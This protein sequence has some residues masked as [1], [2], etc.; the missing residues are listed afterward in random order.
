LE[1][2]RIAFLPL[3]SCYGCQVNTLDLGEEVLR[4]AEFF[5]ISKFSLLGLENSE[6]GYDI[7]IVEGMVS[8][9][10]EDFLKE[11]ASYAHRVVALGSCA[12][13]AW[14]N[15]E[16]FKPV[17]EV[18]EKADILPGCPY[19]KE[20]LRAYLI[21][22]LRGTEFSLPQKNVCVEH[23][24]RGGRCVM[25]EGGFCMGPVTRAGCGA[26]CLLSG[27]TC[28]GC[29]GLYEDANIKAH[30]KRLLSKYPKDLIIEWY[31]RLGRKAYEEVMRICQDG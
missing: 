28:W 27:G 22:C 11:L 4:I 29:R 24:L 7:L 2:A 23:I 25:L 16:E 13:F 10:D 26:L 21:S 5:T 12:S 9:D 20:E 6:Q 3:T 1:K 18:I 15:W 8:K 17:P 31:K 30:V 19:V 14:L